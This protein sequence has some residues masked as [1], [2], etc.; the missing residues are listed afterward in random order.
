ME[1]QHCE[2]QK[3]EKSCLPHSLVYIFYYTLWNQASN[4]LLW[5]LCSFMIWPRNIYF[6][7]SHKSLLIFSN[8]SSKERNHAC[9]S[10][11]LQKDIRSFVCSFVIGCNTQNKGQD[12]TYIGI[13]R[14][15]SSSPVWYL[16]HTLFIWYN[17]LIIFYSIPEIWKNKGHHFFFFRFT[18][19]TSY[20]V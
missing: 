9:T 2:K 12:T 6:F 19:R 20:I 1:I 4:L 7:T 8:S 14:S 15:L 13:Q 11:N 17:F 5:I 10:A 16:K 3:V 18:F